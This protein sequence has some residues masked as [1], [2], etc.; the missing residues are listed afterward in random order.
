MY[1]QITTKC[2]MTCEHCC[3]SCTMR[4]KHGDYNTIIDSIAFARDYTNCISLGGGEPTLHPRFFDILR[5]CLEDF[6]YVWFATN[7]SQTD[8]MFRISNIL[9][10]CDYESFECECDSEQVEEYGC[11]CDHPVIYQENKLGVA[12]STDYFHDPIDLRVRDLWSRRANTHGRNT[13]Y[14]LRDITQ[15][16]SGVIGQG[17]A[18]KNGYTNEGCVCSDIIIKPDGKLRL[19]G[20]ARSPVIGDVW[21][22]IEEKWQNYRDDNGMYHNTNCAFGRG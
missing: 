16:M 17:R 11:E 4:G 8:S 10:D 2:N 1:L 3:Y 13:G 21:S 19:C 15:S 5:H 9:D 12:L 7:G 14:E 22:G 18:R 6:D 20:C